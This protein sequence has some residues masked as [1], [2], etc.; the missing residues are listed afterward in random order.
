[1]ASEVLT[2]ESATL[3][4]DACSG[5]GAASTIS[6]SS[7]DVSNGNCYGSPSRRPTTS[8]TSRR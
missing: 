6:G 7:Y 4:D 3:A 5:F 8:A 1:M 2:V